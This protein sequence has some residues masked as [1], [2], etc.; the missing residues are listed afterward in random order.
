ME[1]KSV[2]Y[3]RDGGT[4]QIDT[5]EGIFCFDY[6]IATVTPGRLYRGYPEKDNSNLIEDSELLETALLEALIKYKKYEE[7]RLLELD[8]MLDSMRKKVMKKLNLG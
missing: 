6:R 1:I 3:Y 8:F 4:Q 7:L 2:N 5:N